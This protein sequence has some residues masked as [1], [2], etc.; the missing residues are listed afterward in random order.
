MG[1]EFVR[2]DLRRREKQR[3]AI[4]LF[5]GTTDHFRGCVG[6]QQP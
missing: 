1:D 3:R 5:I 6:H 2:I 4:L